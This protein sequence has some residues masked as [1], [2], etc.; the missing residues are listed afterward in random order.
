MLFAL[1]ATGLYAAVLAAGF[2]QPRPAVEVPWWPQGSLSLGVEPAAW[3][4][5]LSVTALTLA[6]LLTAPARGAR[7]PL[8]W[9]SSLFILAAGMPALFSANFLTLT[10]AW[11][12]LDAVEL[13]VLLLQAATNVERRRIAAVFAA[14]FGGMMTAAWLAAVQ[15]AGSIVAR[16][17]VTFEIG[18]LL[19]VAMRLGVFPPHVP[20]LRESQPLRRGLGT[21][22]R[23]VSPAASLWLLAGIAGGEL[24]PRWMSW[25]MGAALLAGLAG[26]LGWLTASDALDGRP[27]WVL[28][29]SSLAVGAALSGHPYAAVSWG[30]VMIVCGGTLFLASLREPA[31]AWIPLLATALLVGLPYTP[32]WNAAQGYLPLKGGV[33]WLWMAVHFLMTAGYVRFLWPGS[34]SPLL[35][36]GERAAYALGMALLLGSGIF[37]GVRLSVQAGP[38]GWEHLPGLAG[39]ALLLGGIRRFGDRLPRPKGRLFR[40]LPRLLSFEW[41]YRRLWGAFRFLTVISQNLAALLEGESGLLWMLVLLLVLIAALFSGGP[42]R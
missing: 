1:L 22:L 19:A 21:T 27:F 3:P 30:V 8:G 12:L 35:T 13:S 14:R 26:A 42:S 36:R 29:I 25:L 40:S 23:L 7:R 20:F 10:L 32:G 4:F 11:A 31:L 28:G 33:S 37:L 24:F 15:G 9:G 2:L 18:L 16:R 17:S 39:G 5:A 41:F 6:V 34:P 38:G